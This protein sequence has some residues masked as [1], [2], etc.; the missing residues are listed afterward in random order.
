MA[1]SKEISEPQVS[2]KEGDT[3]DA[4][5][6]DNHKPKKRRRIYK[7]E[8]EKRATKPEMTPEVPMGQR[9]SDQELIKLASVKNRYDRNKGA[10]YAYSYR[11]T[12]LGAYFYLA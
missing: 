6:S 9:L 10:P 5:E 1:P 12:L 7:T 11:G 3:G 8:V 4:E 2:D